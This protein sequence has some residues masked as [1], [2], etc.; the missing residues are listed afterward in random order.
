[1]QWYE[2]LEKAYDQLTDEEELWIEKNYEDLEQSLKQLQKEKKYDTD[3]I[4]EDLTLK[5][6]DRNRRQ[7]VDAKVSRAFLFHWFYLM[8]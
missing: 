8:D 7:Q 2:D 6:I 1:M 3:D 4:D 5:F